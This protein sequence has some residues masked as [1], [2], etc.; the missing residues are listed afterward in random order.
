LAEG[1]DQDDRTEAA[2]PRR[3]QRAR[4]E[5]RVPISRELPAFAG[6][7]AATLALTMAAPGAAQE[8]ARR[9]AALLAHPHEM[10]LS[11]AGGAMRVSME[12]ALRMAAP[13]VLAVLTGGIAAVLLQSGFLMNLAALRPDPKRISPTAGLQRLF[14]ADNLVE[15][16]KSLAKL[17]VSA[18]PSGRC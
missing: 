2:T 14:G 17:A 6:L 3:L 1:A 10:G 15:C 16:G 4:D 13:F 9:L 11:D 5:G 7:A 12:T 8:G 18:S